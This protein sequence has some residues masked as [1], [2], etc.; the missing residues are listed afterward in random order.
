M[1]TT[2]EIQEF[3]LCGGWTNTWSVEED[4]GTSVPTVYD[5]KKDAEDDLD[6]FFYQM[7]EDFMNGYIEDMP[8]REDFRIVEVTLS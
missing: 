7:H 2:Y 4:D 6:D 3:C 1:T 8:D 5:S